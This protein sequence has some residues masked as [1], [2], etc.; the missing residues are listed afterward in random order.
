MQIHAVAS[1]PSI[2][3]YPGLLPDLNHRLFHVEVTRCLGLG[4]AHGGITAKVPKYPFS[5]S[6]LLA[7]VPEINALAPLPGLAASEEKN[8]FDKHHTPLPGD[9]DMLEDNVID[10]RDVQ[11]GEGRD[12]SNH[13]AAEQK[14]VAPDVKHPLGEIALG[15]GLHAEEAAAHI[16]H[17]P[18]EEE[19]EPCHAHEGRSSGAEHT[20][21]FG[22]VVAVAARGQVA[23]SPTKEDERERGET[24]SRHP[25]AVDHGVDY[26]FPGENT[27]FLLSLVYDPRKSD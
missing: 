3:C 11:D 20:V 1:L 26:D 13:D 16:N 5:A 12:E 21:A 15:I 7:G 19:S 22:A 25:D 2:C 17:L 24:E 18:G 27:L 23:I 14:L 6:F 10:H 9:T 4:P 8:R